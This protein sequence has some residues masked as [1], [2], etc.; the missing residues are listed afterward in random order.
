MEHEQ[1]VW[2][3]CVDSFKAAYVELFCLF[4]GGNSPVEVVEEV[5]V[6]MVKELTQE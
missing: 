5:T 3:C 4:Y 1:G 2:H 6:D